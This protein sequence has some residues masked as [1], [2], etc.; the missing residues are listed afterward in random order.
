M[1]RSL[2]TI[3]SLLT[4]LIAVNAQRG[5]NY[6]HSY[7]G[8][9]RLLMRVDS[10]AKNVY[11]ALMFPNQPKTALNY[12]PEVDSI[13][14][15]IYFK[16]DEPVESYRYSVL[17]DNKPILVNKSIEKGELKTVNRPDEVLLAKTLGDF[18]VKDKIISI[19]IYSVENPENIWKSV[20]YGKRI[21]K[22][23]IK[24]LSK[25]FATDKGVDY[26]RILNPEE[27]IKLSI[28][29]KDEQLTILKDVSE[30]DYL[31]YTTIKDKQT[32]QIIFESKLWEY[33][34]TVDE[35]DKFM[36]YVRL[37]KSIFKKSGDYEI[38]IQPLI[39]WKK[40]FD[41]N[42]SAKDIEEY[43]ARYT[44][45]IALEQENYTKKELLQ[46][47]LMAA[48][49]VGIA[50]FLILYFN[51]KA[52]K[53]KLAQKEQQ[54]NI[55]KL[56]L[57]SIRSQ[58]NPHFLFNALAGIQN[59]M[60]K[61]EVDHANQYLAKFARL[62]RT[63][64]D[65]KERISLAQEEKLLHDYLQMEQLRFGFTYK[66][67]HSKSLDLTNIEI[68]SMLLQPFVE[69]AVKHAV[70]AKAGAGEILISFLQEGHDLLLSVTDNGP[71]FDVAKQHAGLGLQLS[72]HRIA[73]LNS[74]Y[75]ENHI[76]L[77][78]V[79]N[80]DGTKINITL[81]YWL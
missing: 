27:N 16:L 26:D 42:M 34:G 64:L 76:T 18:P 7:A 10:G 8:G 37:D 45:S 9:G 36:P 72:R 75:K 81:K 59:L 17:V 44:L 14:V 53:K 56:Q 48:L 15:Q 74:I 3:L 35:N 5:I 2:L 24:A 54:E 52:N 20:F 19:L 32:G 25:R 46:Y 68:P 49:P 55:A 80:S 67:T 31:Y 70:A 4:M 57:S 40:C 78:M 12:L 22:A 29:E 63:V 43:T 6:N 33:G 71:G 69:N 41:C 11:Y 1:K 60:N 38:S 47:T 13:N 77:G 62:T 50:F 66:I 21:P 79:S 61:N 58:L 28:T 39:D 51:K 73:L 23:V 65:D 30:I